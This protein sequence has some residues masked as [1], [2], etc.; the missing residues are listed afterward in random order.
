MKTLAI[1]AVL[2]ACAAPSAYALGRDLYPNF[3]YDECGYPRK[4]ITHWK[5]CKRVSGAIYDSMHSQRQ[6]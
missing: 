6:K 5:N 4:N 3:G 2:V 1:A